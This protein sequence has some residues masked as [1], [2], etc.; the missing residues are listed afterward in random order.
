MFACGP[1][2]TT[3]GGHGTEYAKNIPEV[4]R[5]NFEQ[6]FIR[7]PK[8]AAEAQQQVAELKQ[9]GVDCIKAVMESGASGML[10]NRMDPAIL[11]AIGEAAKEHNLPLVVH[12]GEAQDVADALAA[13]A[14]QH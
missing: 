4:A 10:F 9:R 11:K 7:I 6:Q 1:L 12:T 13:G 3:A 14:I 2:F 5:A 8:T